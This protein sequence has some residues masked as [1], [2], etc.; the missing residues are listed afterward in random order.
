MTLPSEHWPHAPEG[1][2]AGVDPPHSLSPVQARQVCVA[3]LHTGAM[4]PHWALEVQGTQVAVPTSQAGVEPVHLLA[5][6]AEHWPQAPD[7]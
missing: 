2:Q 1:W 5:L 7:D 4:P 6:V 3:R